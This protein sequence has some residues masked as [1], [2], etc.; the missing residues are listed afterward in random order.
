[1]ETETIDA[2]QL[3]PDQVQ[4]VPQVEILPA[5][6][7]AEAWRSDLLKTFIRVIFERELQA[8]IWLEEARSSRMENALDPLDERLKQ[9]IGRYFPRRG[10]I[11][12]AVYSRLRRGLN[13][14]LLSFRVRREFYRTIYRYVCCQGVPDREWKLDEGETADDGIGVKFYAALA[15]F[16]GD[17]QSQVDLGRLDRLV[18]SIVDWCLSI[19]PY[20]APGLCEQDLYSILEYAQIEVS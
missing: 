18:R 11:T 10:R 12:A 20:H 5:Q 6:I 15:G 17:Q 1:M 9:L 4:Y 19:L 16:L 8:I 3:V 2:V 14:F 13:R 7:L